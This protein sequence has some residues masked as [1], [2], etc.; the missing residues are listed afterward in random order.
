MRIMHLFTNFHSG[1]RIQEVSNSYAGFTGYVRTEA[2]SAKKKLRIPRY[3]ATCGRSLK[4][5]LSSFQLRS[6]SHYVLKY[7]P[8]MDSKV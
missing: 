1:E 7:I 4:V 8:S 6:L 5:L 2:V 3:P